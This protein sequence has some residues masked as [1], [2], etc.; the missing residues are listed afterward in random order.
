MERRNHVVE[1]REFFEMGIVV[2][3]IEIS[4]SWSRI[5][6]IYDDAITSLRDA[7]G[8]INASAHS[9]HAYRSG[10]NLYFSFAVRCDAEEMEASYFDCWRRVMEATV[11]HGGGVAHH[12]GAGRLRKRWIE[13]DL[14]AGGVE[15]LRTI[16]RAVDPAG[17]MNPGNL[18]PD[19]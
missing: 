13:H 18:I 8:V 10:V 5:D 7:A 6:A 15:L 17:I 4:A 16:Q 14:G 3:T 9:S 1:W 2:D 19:A 12:H 11:R